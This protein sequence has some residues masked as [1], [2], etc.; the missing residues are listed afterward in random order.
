MKS[1]IAVAGCT[2]KMGKMLIR[3][4]VEQSDMVLSGVLES[5]KHLAIGVDPLQEMGLRSDL[6]ITADVE[7][8][9]QNSDVLVDF[10]RPEATRLHLLACQKTGTALVIGT[11]GL[12]E[13][14]HQL[15]REV[16]ALIP[17]FWAPNMSVGV[18]V[19]LELL[20]TATQLL[21]EGFDVEIV[22]AHHRHKVDSPS[23]TALKMGQVIAQAKGLDLHKV[24]RFDR[25]GIT[26]PRTNHEIG[27]ATIRGGDV[28]GDHTVNFLGMGERVEITHKASSRQTFAAGAIRA[29]R[30]LVKQPPGLYGM[31][32]LLGAEHKIDSP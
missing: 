8:V 10:T 28:I 13:A 21:G 4:I 14:D 15:L 31:L 27:F 32:D 25:H 16:S 2:G 17:V 5:E 30:F 23:G 18:H 19:V 7:Q 26:G 24:G 6:K 22:E 20:K 29:S 11:T 1:R 12:T 3:T 9:V